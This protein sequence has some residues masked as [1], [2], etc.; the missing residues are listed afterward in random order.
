MHLFQHPVDRDGA[1]TLKNTDIVARQGTRSDLSKTIPIS[2]HGCTY[3][4][5]FL[6]LLDWVGLLT[7][8]CMGWFWLLTLLCR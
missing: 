5:F 4:G 6:K 2:A 8:L 3:A 7:L 1:A